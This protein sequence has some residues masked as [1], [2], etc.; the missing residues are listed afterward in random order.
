MGGTSHRH[1]GALPS[2]LPAAPSAAPRG[3]DGPAGARSQ[4]GV[5]PTWR[6]PAAE[7]AFLPG[8]PIR[9][10][11]ALRT[12]QSAS[13]E[14]TFKPCSQELPPPRVTGRGRGAALRANR[15]RGS[16]YR[17][18]VKPMGLRRGARRLPAERLVSAGELLGDRRGSPA[19]GG[20]WAP[21]RA[22]A[23]MAK[24]ARER[25]RGGAGPGARPGRAGGAAGCRA[26]WG[27]GGA[28]HLR[29]TEAP[30]GRRGAPGPAG[31]LPRAVCAARRE[32]AGPPRLALPHPAL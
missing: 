9:A 29:G 13:R 12:G 2:P 25:R 17:H 28:G 15:G 5:L 22:A 18:A 7:G 1:A 19:A 27:P 30:P 20:S 11:V 32:G 23:V 10:P 4:R 24:G 14:R 3:T 6:G 26:G 21:G 8:P 31:L 16:V